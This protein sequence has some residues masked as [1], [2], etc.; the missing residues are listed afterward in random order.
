MPQHGL[1]GLVPFD[2]LQTDAGA[3]EVDELLVRIALLNSCK[4]PSY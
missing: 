2:M 4:I 3:C 1:G